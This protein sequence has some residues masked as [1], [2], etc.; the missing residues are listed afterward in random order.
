M[1]DDMQRA[2]KWVPVLLIALTAVLT[3][4]TA[5]AASTVTLAWDYGTAPAD[6]AGFRIYYA[7][8]P[9]VTVAAANKVADV[10]ATARQAQAVNLS[11]GTACFVATAYDSKGNESGK[12]N[13]VCTDLD[14]TAPPTPG[15]VRVQV[16]VKVDVP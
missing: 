5:Q 9:G 12:S 6:L 14:T 13:E 11:D 8:A 1:E 15:N 4:G 3:L 2:K 10:A 7:P 16:V